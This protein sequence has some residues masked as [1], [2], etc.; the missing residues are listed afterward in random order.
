MKQPKENQFLAHNLPNLLSMRE[1][2]AHVLYA[3]RTERN[4]VIPPMLLHVAESSA[5]VAVATMAKDQYVDVMIDKI[6]NGTIPEKFFAGVIGVGSSAL[7][8]HLLLQHIRDAKSMAQKN[9]TI[10]ALKESLKAIDEAI[11][12]KKSE[13]GE[14]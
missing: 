12:I 3:E 10:R 8:L 4:R 7:A 11:E 1:Q 13:K 5:V 14:E 9:I 6:E 2:Y